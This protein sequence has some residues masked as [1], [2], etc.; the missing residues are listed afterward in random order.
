MKTIHVHVLKGRDWIK[1]Q[2]QGMGHILLHELDL[3]LQ[4][5]KSALPRP[6][7][8]ANSPVLVQKHLWSG[9]SHNPEC[10]AAFDRGSQAL[11]GIGA[12]LLQVHITPFVRACA[13]L[14]RR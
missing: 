9:A 8:A 4:S 12:V 2:K 3:W 13:P 14:S 5:E 10:R 6:T 1:A 7:V 11:S